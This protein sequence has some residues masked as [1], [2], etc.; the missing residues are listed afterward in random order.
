MADLSGHVRVAKIYNLCPTWFLRGHCGSFTPIFMAQSDI[1]CHFVSELA[2]VYG[3]VYAKIFRRK[4]T[5]L[6]V[7][8]QNGQQTDVGPNWDRNRAL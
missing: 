3:G 8:R 1:S 4:D 7:K 6:K 5:V 2:Q